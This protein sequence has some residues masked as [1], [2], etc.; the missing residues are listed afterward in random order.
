M[1][2]RKVQPLNNG[3]CYLLAQINAR[4]RDCGKVFPKRKRLHP[5]NT[6]F[7]QQLSVQLAQ[8]QSQQIKV[9]SR[10]FQSNPSQYMK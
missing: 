9:Q 7:R 2:L 8:T 10:E 3:K 4:S 6:Q 5:V 1:V